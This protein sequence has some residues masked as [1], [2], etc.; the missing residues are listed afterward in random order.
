MLIDSVAVGPVPCRNGLQ[1]N[2][3]RSRLFVHLRP[4]KLPCS[5]T[6]VLELAVFAGSRNLSV[7]HVGRGPAL[8]PRLEPRRDDAWHVAAARVRG[9]KRHL[10]PVGK[11]LSPCRV[12]FCSFV[13][14]LFNWVHS[15][16][17]LWKLSWESAVVFFLSSLG[18]TGFPA[19]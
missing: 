2:S 19:D 5:R 13:R 9:R 16:A 18:E 12:V 6:L 10:L 1:V 4:S 15:R 17:R 14:E 11:W 7:R 8:G 3:S